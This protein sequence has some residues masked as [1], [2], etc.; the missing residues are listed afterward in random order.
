MLAESANEAA[1]R[2][3][4]G[5]SLDNFRTRESSCGRGSVC[6]GD[7][8]CPL[9]ERSLSASAF[10][11]PDVHRRG[12][13]RPLFHREQHGERQYAEDEIQQLPRYRFHSVSIFSHLFNEQK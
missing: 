1:A 9:A 12:L 5:R 11:T 13:P 4:R 8:G 2:G 10:V 6:P 3:W 7:L